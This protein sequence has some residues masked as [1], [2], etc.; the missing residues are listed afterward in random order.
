MESKQDKNNSSKI[1]K[2]LQSNN[3]CLRLEVNSRGAYA[4]IYKEDET[5]LVRHHAWSI[6]EAINMA[7]DWW[8]CNGRK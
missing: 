8:K 7:V 1:E 4:F 2:F 5:Y 3:L 6:N